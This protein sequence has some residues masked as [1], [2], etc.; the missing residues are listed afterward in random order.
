M[1]TGAWGR[2]CCLERIIN[3]HID[4]PNFAVK[5]SL[6]NFTYFSLN[7]VRW[8]WFCPGCTTIS[9][10]T[11]F[12]FYLSSLLVFFYWVVSLLWAPC[13][14]WAHRC[15]HSRSSRSPAGQ[16]QAESSEFLPSSLRYLSFYSSCWG[17][18]RLPKLSKLLASLVFLLF[19]QKPFSLSISSWGARGIF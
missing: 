14:S 13:W 7:F 17:T 16:S 18:W 2:T 11:T 3:Y 9:K 4:D 15:H 10:N 1:W 12:T 5:S 6:I 19:S 8:C